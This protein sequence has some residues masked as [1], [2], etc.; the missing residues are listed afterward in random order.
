MVQPFKIRDSPTSWRK[1]V[2]K[3]P[4]KYRVLGYIPSIPGGWLAGISNEAS[5]VKNMRYTWKIG[6]KYWYWMNLPPTQPGWMPDQK[7]TPRMLNMYRFYL[8]STP[9]PQD[10][11]FF[12]KGLVQDSRCLNMFG[13]ST[14]WWGASILNLGWGWLVAKIEISDPFGSHPFSGCVLKCPWKLVNGWKYKPLVNVDYKWHRT[15]LHAK[16]LGCPWKFSD[17]LGTY[18]LFHL[19]KRDVF[20][21]KMDTMDFIQSM[22]ISNQGMYLSPIWFIHILWDCIQPYG[23]FQK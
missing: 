3:T 15:D 5:T 17:P 20:S 14:C 8:G 9:L 1:L 23:C 21:T 11:S 7:K 10:A 6:R 2:G 16:L 13:S 22:G 19:L 12:Y 18:G 4:Q